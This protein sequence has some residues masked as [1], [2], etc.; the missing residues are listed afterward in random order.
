MQAAVAFLSKAV[1]PVLVGGVKLR[2]ARARAQFLELADASRYPV[3]LMPNAKGCARLHLRPLML[4][5]LA[6]CIGGGS[7]GITCTS[8]HHSL[9]GLPSVGQ[10]DLLELLACL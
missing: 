6:S 4:P 9:S 10:R 5:A 8:S 7:C 1:K 2:A 3:A